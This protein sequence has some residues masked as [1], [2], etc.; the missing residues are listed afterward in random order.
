MNKLYKEMELLEKELNK[1]KE[2]K[3]KT[4]MNDDR[5]YDMLIEDIS[6]MI[7]EKSEEL[8]ELEEQDKPYSPYIR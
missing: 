5:A 8:L 3:S 4:K 1:V 2:L 6:N 7:S